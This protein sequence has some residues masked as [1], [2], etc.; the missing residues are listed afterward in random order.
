MHLQLYDSQEKN[1]T[2]TT[3]RRAWQTVDMGA[4]MKKADEMCD[5]MERIVA[6]VE[7][8][9]DPPWRNEGETFYKVELRTG[10]V[11]DIDHACSC[12]ACGHACELFVIVL[13]FF[14]TLGV[15]YLMLNSKEMEKERKQAGEGTWRMLEFL[16]LMTIVMVIFTVRTLLKR[17][18]KASSD[19]FVS[20]V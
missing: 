8:K 18:R 16:F 6:P 13:C 3:R 5:T 10:I 20:E 7:S 14:C 12:K 2:K 19:V 15:F 1:K 9:S 4:L 17:W 11:C